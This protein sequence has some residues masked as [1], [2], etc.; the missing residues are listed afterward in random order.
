MAKKKS[1]KEE[2]RGRK[3]LPD[4]ERRDNRNVVKTN[5]REQKQLERNAKKAGYD[6]VVVWLRELGLQ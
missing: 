1:K 5:D 6:S 3:S 4:S 2:T